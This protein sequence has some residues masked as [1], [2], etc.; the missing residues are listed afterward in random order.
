MNIT[1]V[2]DKTIRNSIEQGMALNDYTAKFIDAFYDDLDTLKIER[3]EVYP[4]ATECVPEMIAIIEDLL[5]KGFAYKS[6]DGS[7]Y[8]NIA[9]FAEYGQ[10]AHI[11]P[12]ELKVGA[13]VDQ[14]EY[15][16]DSAADFALWKAY[17]DGDGD[18]CWESPFG[19]G[20]PGWHIEC[21][22][23]AMK[24][25]G[26]TLDIH[27]GGVD[28]IFPHHEDE[29]AQSEAHTGEKF[30]HYWMHS[31]HLI[32]E[33]RK[34]S[35]SAGN[36]FTLRD[37]LDKGYSGSQIR[38]LLLS[39]HYRQQLNFTFQGLDAAKASL[40]R[41]TDFLL[42]LSEITAEGESEAVTE[43]LDQARLKFE[44]A[45]DDDLNI[46]GALGAVFELIHALNKQLAESALGKQDAAN[47]A[48][49]FAR[50]DTVLG[51]LPEKAAASDDDAVAQD[52]AEQRVQARKDKDW[53]L[54]DKLRD[55][56]ADM[57]YVVEDTPSGP[58]IK[59]Q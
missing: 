53:A 33:N 15:S 23:M 5:A 32:V 35:K 57:G 38:Y 39:S 20:R 49:F 17:S 29:I 11:K 34:M 7:V 24:H 52:L 47:V 56:I 43:L 18:V 1:D 14:D 10:L 44:A 2:D 40:T 30:V 42:R 55:K 25:L 6:E 37:L 26:P 8:Y 54:A 21:S 58:R 22:A 41:I 28:N 4:R 9:K 27:T 12:D 45:L 31:A 59:K 16:K 19:K 51:I 13:R 3:A 48:E 50:I 46:S 36:F